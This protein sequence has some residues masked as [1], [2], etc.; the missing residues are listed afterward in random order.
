MVD[1]WG[2]GCCVGGTDGIGAGGVNGDDGGGITTQNN[3]VC[4][5]GPQ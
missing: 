1:L 4:I 2:G 5:G 3:L